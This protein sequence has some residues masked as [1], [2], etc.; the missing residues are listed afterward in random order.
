MV[1]IGSRQNTFFPVDREMSDYYKWAAEM[2]RFHAEMDAEEEY[3][4]RVKIKSLRLRER[5]TGEPKQREPMVGCET[6][7][8]EL[9]IHAE[10]KTC[11]VCSPRVL[12]K[13]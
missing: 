5:A 9:I 2:A 8:G 1:R 10:S 7:E 13:P 6:S 11:E 3:D 12:V 4:D